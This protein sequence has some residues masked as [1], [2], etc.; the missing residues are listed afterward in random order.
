VVLILNN[1][2]FFLVSKQVRTAL[3]SLQNTT[4]LWLKSG[5]FKYLSG[6]TTFSFFQQRNVTQNVINM[7]MQKVTLYEQK[8]T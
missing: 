7:L 4:K 5:F 1:C 2:G 6:A 3:N 8:S